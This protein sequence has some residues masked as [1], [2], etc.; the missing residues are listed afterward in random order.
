[1]SRLPLLLA[2]LFAVNLA[3]AE[4]PRLRPADWAR[5]VVGSVLDNFCQVSPELYRSEQP[6]AA[7]LPDLQAFGVATLLNLRHY[8][9]DD[10][11]FGQRGLELLHYPM[12]AGSVSIPDLVKV[13]RLFRAA[14]K[15]VL[16]HCW[17]GS[18]RTGFVVAGYR[19][20]FLNWTPEQA[21]AELRLGGFGYHAATYPNIVRELR[22]MDVAAVRKAVLE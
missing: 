13:L 16:V 12:D 21:I 10:P 19:I 2:F 4:T 22:G 14:K 8:H 1:M 17:H 9:D 15:P 7:S 3:G 5:P 18:D 20:V 11:A 6:V